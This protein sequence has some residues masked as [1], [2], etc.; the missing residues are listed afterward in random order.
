[1]A[2]LGKTWESCKLLKSD[3]LCCGLYHSQLPWLFFISTQKTFA[4]VFYT[5]ICYTLSKPTV[6]EQGNTQ[7]VPALIGWGKGGNVTSARWQVTLCNP[8]QH[9]SFR[10]GVAKLFAN[11]YIQLLTSYFT[12]HLLTSRFLHRWTLCKEGTTSLTVNAVKQSI[13]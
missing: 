12:G 10:S 3:A 7:R 8:I 9:V 1:M 4:Q 11:C 13:K 6:S 5:C 2:S